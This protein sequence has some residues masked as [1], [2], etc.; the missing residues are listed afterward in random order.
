[1]TAVDFYFD[2]LCPWAYR[3][4]TWIREVAPHR[5][6][7]I[8]WCPF[9]LEEKNWESSGKHPWERDWSFS[10]ALLRVAV[11][12]RRE[13]GNDTVNRFYEA[14]GRRC[15]DEGVPVFLRDRLGEL[16][17]ELGFDA[18]LVD[19][20]HLDETVTADL[21]RDHRI[22]AERG[23]FGVPTLGVAGQL[24][25]GPV[26]TPAPIGDA[27]LRLWDLVIGW[28]EFPDLYEM[29]RPKGAAEQANIGRSFAKSGEARTWMKR[30]TQP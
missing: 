25:F 23:V 7:D 8:T 15:H 29:Q 27:A 3:A 11:R 5:G 24:L 21:R 30:R 6:L 9:S 26:I 19:D 4:S 18:A 13:G 10:W 16:V 12:L 14:A 28:T 1:M 2:P 17:T 20:S 22:A